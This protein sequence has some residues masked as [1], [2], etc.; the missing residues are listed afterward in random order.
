MKEIFGFNVTIAPSCV[1]AEPS[2]KAKAQEINEAFANKNID[3]IFCA[4]GGCE[5]IRVIPYLDTEIIRVNWKPFFGFS[6]ATILHLFFFDCWDCCMTS[7]YGGAVMCQF[8]MQGPRMHEHTLNSIKDALNRTKNKMLAPSHDII[9]DY[10]N[11]MDKA[12]LKIEQPL[13]YHSINSSFLKNKVS[14]K[15]PKFD[16]SQETLGLCLNFLIIYNY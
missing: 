14:I 13:T 8:A 4:I 5:S 15:I 6:D 9:V 16:F 1:S 10:L 3:A 7:F 11:W 12:N 2:P